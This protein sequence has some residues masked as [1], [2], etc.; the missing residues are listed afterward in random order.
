MWLYLVH[1]VEDRCKNDA[2]SQINMPMRVVKHVWCY[3]VW[4][5]HCYLDEDWSSTLA[6]WEG[7]IWVLS[8]LTSTNFLRNASSSS[9][10][11]LGI[12]SFDK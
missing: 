8:K 4:T 11:L 12:L 3:S 7:V 2:F 9:I 5:F 6:P 1:D 10:P